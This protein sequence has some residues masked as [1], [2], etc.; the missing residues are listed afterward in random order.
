MEQNI[1]RFIPFHKDSL[2]VHTIN[3]VYETKTQ[4]YKKLSS[5]SVYKMYYVCSGK[6]YI[7]TPGKITP[8]SEG[9]LFFTFP[10][11]SFSIESVEN[12]TYMYIS[13]VGLRGN[14]IME[15]LNIN[16]GNFIFHD[17]EEV[18]DFWKKGILISSGMTDLIS[19]S[20]LLYTFSFLG[21]RIIKKDNKKQSHSVDLIKKYIDEHFTDTDFSLENISRELS[22]N[23][24]YISHVFKKHFGTGITE[25]VNTVRIQNACTMIEQGFTSV[26]D[27]ADRSGYSDSQYF[28]KMFKTKMG[29]TPTEYIKERQK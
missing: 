8:L 7:H 4:S 27:I 14:M 18:Y 1:C 20:V 22:Y 23:K 19:E 17:S 24:K 12:F 25:Y 10:S 29:F 26:C 13:F 15:S 28:S 11:Y 3:F 21:D 6:G 16:N 9:D 5:E 2:S